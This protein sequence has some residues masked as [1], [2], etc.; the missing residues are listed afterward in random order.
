[1][2][3]VYILLCKDDSLYTGIATDVGRRFEE[4]KAGK[5]SKYTRARK[6]KQ[7]VY[8]EKHKTRSE[9][10]KREAQIK[11]MTRKKKLELIG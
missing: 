5:G 2:Y 10:Q 8:T 7:V 9:A 4:H 6:V 1:M 3:F 11:S